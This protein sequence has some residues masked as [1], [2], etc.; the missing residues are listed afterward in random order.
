MGKVSVISP[1]ATDDSDAYV[2]FDARAIILD[3]PDDGRVA[4]MLP[5]HLA[6]GRP[7]RNYSNGP[8]HADAALV[9]S[10]S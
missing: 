2:T 4:D 3:L 5:A 8:S 9:S 1:L 10:S 7:A 6:P